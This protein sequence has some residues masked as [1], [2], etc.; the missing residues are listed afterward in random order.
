MTAV[1]LPSLMTPS[2]FVFGEIKV[3]FDDFSDDTCWPV[4]PSIG[5]AGDVSIGDLH[6]KVG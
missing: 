5:E 2:S 3:L 1:M 6:K 4:T